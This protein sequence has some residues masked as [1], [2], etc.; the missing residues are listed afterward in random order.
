MVVF[1]AF[2]SL[3]GVAVALTLPGWS[4]LLL[5]AGPS[6]VASLWLWWRGRQDKPMRQDAAEADRSGGPFRRKAAVARRKP[7]PHVIIDGSN[8]MHWQ[9]GAPSLV[10]VVSAILALESKGFTVGVI[11]DANVGYKTHDRYQDDR[12]MAR[13]LSL[14]EE[15]VLVVPKGT[16]ADEYILTAAQD[17]AARVVTNDRFRDW[18]DRFP[19]VADPGFLIRGGANDQGEVWLNPRD[20]TAGER[21]VASP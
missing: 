14:P 17:L 8:V 3:F 7:G 16:P 2:L 9:G 5:L 15:R 12:E 18:R 6:L 13:R 1:L 20:L 11:F 10:P 19:R 4:D 21:Q